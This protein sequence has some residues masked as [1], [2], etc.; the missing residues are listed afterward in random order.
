M[1]V[2]TCEKKIVVFYYFAGRARERKKERIR[3]ENQLIQ[4]SYLYRYYSHINIITHTH[5]IQYER[6]IYRVYAK[7]YTTN[8]DKSWNKRRDVRRR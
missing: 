8:N 7:H 1:N 2:E 6:S 5:A 3:I 4:S